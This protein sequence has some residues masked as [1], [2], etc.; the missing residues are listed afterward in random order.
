MPFTCSTASYLAGGCSAYLSLWFSSG[1][2]QPFFTKLFPAMFRSLLGRVSSYK[3]FGATN[4]ASSKCEI[5][6]RRNDMCRFSPLPPPLV[7]GGGT[8]FGGGTFLGGRSNCLDPDL[9]IL[10]FCRS[11]SL[12]KAL[13]NSRIYWLKVGGGCH[14]F[15]THIPCVNVPGSKCCRLLCM[16]PDTPVQVCT[17]VAGHIHLKASYTSSIRPHTLVAQG[18]IHLRPHTLVA[19]LV[20]WLKVYT[21][22]LRLV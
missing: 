17:L 9:Y 14:T 2:K 21:S 15:D 19:G 13:R 12:T 18:R 22:S 1:G 16:C 10:I 7:G 3:F 4:R 8:F 11:A 6:S 20:H 5:V